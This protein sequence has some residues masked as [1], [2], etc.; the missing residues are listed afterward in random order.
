M[1]SSEQAGG[2]TTLLS[3]SGSSPEEGPASEQIGLVVAWCR[4]EP[5]RVGEIVDMSKGRGPGVWELGRGAGEDGVAARAGLVRERPGG[6][7][8]TEPLSTRGLSRR[9]LVIRRKRDG[10]LAV[11]NV[12]RASMT[13]DGEATKT[14]TLDEGAVLEVDGQLVLV[15]VR[16]P[17]TMPELRDFDPAG[18]PA[19]GQADA[20]G[21]VGESP[22]AWALRDRI[23]FVAHRDAHVLVL[24]DSGT[25]KELVARAIHQLSARAARTLVA[26]NAATLPEG[27]VD[28]ELFGNAAS[29]PNPGMKAR[30]G[31]VGE[32]DGSTLFLDEIGEL[33]PALQ[34][35]LLRVLDA[36][37]EYHRLG[38]TAARRSDLR[39]VAATNRDLASL[40]HD[41]GARLKLRMHVPPLS[42]RVEDI[43]LLVTH[44]LRG[45]AADDVV[46]AERFFDRDGDGTLQPRVTAELMVALLQHEY[47]LHV[48][49]LEALLWSSLGSSRGD[50]LA[51][52]EEL[53]AELGPKPADEASDQPEP[54]SPDQLEPERIQAVLDDHNGV[55][56]KAWR[57]LGLK[58]RFALIRLIKKHGLVVNKQ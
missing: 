5:Q 23:A 25:G 6:R 46:L 50:R 13:V 45:I 17:E 41:F 51:L 21:L 43:P 33:P 35:H 14:A 57:A 55:Q 48:R 2:D 10:T 37:G 56:E 44:L 1:A 24:G 36:G 30:P 54:V 11:E 28:A 27:I 15:A 20:F 40:K 3:Q 4:G 31:L 8:S 52:T 42:Q 49:E 26:R 39:L 9:Q 34:A 12:G 19:F 38:E 16:R 18:M 47:A 29:Y 22:A 58:N 32:A 7:E 53:R